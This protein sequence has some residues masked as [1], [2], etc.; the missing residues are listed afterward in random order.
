MDRLSLIGQITAIL[1]RMDADKLRVV[2][3]FVR[4]LL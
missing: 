1:R 4:H 3:A 2:L